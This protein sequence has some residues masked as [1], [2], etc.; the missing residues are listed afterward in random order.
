MKA[1]GQFALLEEKKKK[2]EEKV[3]KR[4]EVIEERRGKAGRT[5]KARSRAK[6]A[7]YN[8]GGAGGLG[9]GFAGGQ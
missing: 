7:A 5:L 4:D 8:Y 6:R 9:G 2:E 1:K 3:K